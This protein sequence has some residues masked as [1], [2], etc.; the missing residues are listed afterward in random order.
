MR[1]RW[2]RLPRWARWVLAVYVIGFAEG[3][4]DHVLWMSH[5]GIHAYAR[6]G[7]AP[8]QVFLVLLIVL[9][10]VTTLLCAFVRRAGVWLAALIMI[11]DIAANWAGNWAR[12]PRFIASFWLGELF[13]VLVFVT[14]IPLS[15]AIVGM[16]TS[17]SAG[18]PRTVRRPA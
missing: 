5:G 10:P 4:L 1:E 16:P 17:A 2:A 3:T 12:M 18:R 13:A 9:D 11:L 6:F 8:V 7:Y 15:R 14:A